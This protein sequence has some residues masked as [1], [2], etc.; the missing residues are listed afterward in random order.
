MKYTILILILFGLFGCEGINDQSSK[1]THENWQAQR[2]YYT[3]NNNKI[4]IKPVS[5]KLIVRFSKGQ[6][7]KT[8]KSRIESEP[9]IA[10]QQWLDKLTVVIA[11]SN[12]DSQKNLLNKYFNDPNV[13]SAHPVYKYVNISYPP[14]PNADTTGPGLTYGEMGYTDEFDVQFLDSVSKTKVKQLNK[15]YHVTIIEINSWG[16]VMRVP[17]KADALKIANEYYETGLTKYSQPNFSKN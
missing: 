15:K 4:F 17:P 9:S 2:F 5:T 13:V 10:S 7:Q 14:P 1:P 11:T 12:S 8:I 3:T 6:S 16:N